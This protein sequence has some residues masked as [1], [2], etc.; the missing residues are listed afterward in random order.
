[1][2]N[3]SIYAD[4]I[5]VGGRLQSVF[6]PKTAKNSKT[7]K[8]EQMVDNPMV[9]AAEN[10]YNKLIPKETPFIGCCHTR[11]SRIST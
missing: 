8:P 9:T 10:C 2:T 6:E 4:C 1:M 7:V 5:T 3:I 11:G